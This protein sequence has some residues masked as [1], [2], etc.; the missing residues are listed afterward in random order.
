MTQTLF[1]TISLIRRDINGI[2]I[3]IKIEL[4]SEQVELEDLKRSI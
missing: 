2:I 4:T 3:L 1:I